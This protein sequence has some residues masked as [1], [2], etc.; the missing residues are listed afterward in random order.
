MLNFIKN[1]VVKVVASALVAAG[2]AVLGVIGDHKRN[3]EIEDMK[4]AIEALQNK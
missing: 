3:M 1:P 4:N 2:T